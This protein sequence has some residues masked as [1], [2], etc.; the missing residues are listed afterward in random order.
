MF[1]E[2]NT[3]LFSLEEKNTANIAHP[4]DS[5]VF[6]QHPVMVQIF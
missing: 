2:F 3:A 5:V 4:S 6:P 1:I